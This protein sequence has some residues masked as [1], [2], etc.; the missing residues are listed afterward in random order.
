MSASALNLNEYFIVSKFNWHVYMC[1]VVRV[2]KLPNDTIIE[3]CI[4]LQLTYT[5]H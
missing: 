1:D 3:L 4:L 5:A 2:L